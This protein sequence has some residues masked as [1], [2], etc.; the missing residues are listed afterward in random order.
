MKNLTVGSH[1]KVSRGFYD[2]HGIYCG[3]NTVI[4]YSGLNEP[5]KKGAVEITTLS[6]FMGSAEHISIV[7]YSEWEVPYTRTEIIDR[8]YSKIGEDEYNLLFNNCEHFACWCVTGKKQSEQVN[9]A[10]STAVEIGLTS[11]AIPIIN[12]VAKTTQVTGGCT[13]PIANSSV[14]SAKTI[15]AISGASVAGAS[16]V[17]TGALGA[18][19]LI[20]TAPVSA[21]LIFGGAVVGAIFGGLFD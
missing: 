18:T 6:D 7:H 3:E 2:H 13:T 14:M 8:A 11:K 15:G 12:E 19:A 21:P 5:F 17:A 1:I 9:R 4:H 20:A 16:T 10:K